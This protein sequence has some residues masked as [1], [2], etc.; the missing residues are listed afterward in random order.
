MTEALT[1]LCPHCG[2][3]ATLSQVQGDRC[4]RCGFEFKWFGP[5]ERR[6]ADDYLSILTGEKHFA[7]LPDGM[8][9]VVAHE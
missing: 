6:M 1:I 2:G 5:G 4:T 3:E 9:F 8:G 7:P